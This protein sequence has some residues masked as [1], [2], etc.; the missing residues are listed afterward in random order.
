[1][2]PVTLSYGSGLL[3][4]SYKIGPKIMF[5]QYSSATMKITERKGDE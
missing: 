2:V 3:L 5:L 4:E 1:M